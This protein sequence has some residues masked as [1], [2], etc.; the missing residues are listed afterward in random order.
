MN[1]L[2]LELPDPT[3]VNLIDRHRVQIM[4]FLAPL[5]HRDDQIGRLQQN[6][7]LGHRLT[8]HVMPLA[9]LAQSQAATGAQ[10]VEQLPSLRAMP[11]LIVLRPGDANEVVEA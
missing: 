8:T 7:M 3:H 1:L 5:F 10:P 9:Q 11:N 6:E 4:Q 2:L